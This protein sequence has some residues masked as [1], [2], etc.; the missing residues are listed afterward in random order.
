MVDKS[1]RKMLKYGAAATGAA[2]VP[3]VSS[4]KGTDADDD[5]GYNLDDITVISERDGETYVG[6]A[7]SKK[8]K[9]F[10]DVVHVGDSGTVKKAEVSESQYRTLTADVGTTT[11]ADVQS[12]VG[13]TGDDWEEII[14]RAD[15]WGGTNGDCGAYDYTHRW[16]CVTAEFT[17]DISDLGI[18]AVSAA[19]IGYVGATLSSGVV[20]GVLAGVIAAGAWAIS[21]VV[22]VDTITVGAT[23]F[24]KSAFGW[25]QTLNMSKV[26]T[27]WHV[28]WDD[29]VP[30]GGSPGHPGRDHI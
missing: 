25:T 26:G 8:G 17:R 24:D 20:I 27:G 3:T 13:A 15:A 2:L 28:D 1:R 12:T 23:E 14:E 30:Q 11:H 10:T 22:D 4:A 18:Q 21:W 6:V 7:L 29:L 9:Q 19:L 16:G 5:A